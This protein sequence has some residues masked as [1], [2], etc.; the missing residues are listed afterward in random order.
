MLKVF[1]SESMEEED[2]GSQISQFLEGYRQGRTEEKR[3]S[4]PSLMGYINSLIGIRTVY[5]IVFLVA[6]LMLIQSISKEEP[7]RVGTGDRV[8]RASSSEAE[9]TEYRP[10]DKED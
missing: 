10:E 3:I 9:S 4:G 5:I 7:L 8:D 6:M 1:G 2:Q